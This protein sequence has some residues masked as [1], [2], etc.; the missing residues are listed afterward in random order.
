MVD[1]AAYQDIDLEERQAK[2]KERLYG[3]FQVNEGDVDFK[4]TFSNWEECDRRNRK[5]LPYRKLG[6]SMLNEWAKGWKSLGEREQWNRMLAEANP[7]HICF[8][9]NHML[10]VSAIRDDATSFESLNS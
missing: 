2:A 10:M 5:E 7:S 9:T 6:V 4:W 8:S 3:Y 1:C